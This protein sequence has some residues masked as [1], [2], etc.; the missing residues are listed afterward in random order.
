LA[1]YFVL[2]FINYFP[3]ITQKALIRLFADDT[4]LIIR[5][6]SLQAVQKLINNILTLCKCWFAENKLTLNTEKSDYVVFGTKARLSQAGAIR[7]EIGGTELTRVD[8]Y[9][10]LG[11]TLDESLTL[12]PQIAKLNQI[13]AMKL[14]SFRMMRHCMSAST[15]V[16]IYKATMLPIIDYNDVLYRLATQ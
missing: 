15:A 2:I 1:H 13:M 7:L 4:A 6:K 5:A 3:I 12:I 9:K 8:K 14:N 11:T 16:L 10:Y